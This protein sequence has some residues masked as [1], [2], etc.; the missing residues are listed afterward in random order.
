[1][2]LRRNP[3]AKQLLLEY[4]IVH[5]VEKDSSCEMKGKWRKAFARPDQPLYVEIGTGK[6]QFLARAAQKYP[7][8]NWIGLERIEEPLLKAVRKGAEIAEQNKNLRYIWTDA[9]YLTDVFST[10]EVDRIYLHFSDPWPKKRHAK[11]RL[12]HRRFL[13]IYRQILTTNGDLILKTDSQSLFEFSLEEFK[14][15]GWEVLDLTH[16]LH[17]SPYNKE[18]ITTEYEDKFTQKGMPIYYV[19]VKPMHVKSE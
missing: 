18:N 17:Q 16:N 3:K 7:N 14:E 13:A 6:G 11:R 2:R 4:D 12:T 1:M 15:A 8:I 9:E 19:R 5:R 10:E